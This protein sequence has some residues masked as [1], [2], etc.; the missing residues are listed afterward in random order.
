M[1]KLTADQ[2]HYRKRKKLARRDFIFVPRPN[3][4]KRSVQV[5]RRAICIRVSSDVFE[6]LDRLCQH[7]GKTKQDMVT[8][9]IN[10]SIKQYQGL[11]GGRARLKR[12]DWPER[13]INGTPERR[14][15]ARN[16][17]KQLNLRITSTA[18]KKLQCAC[19]DLNF[20]KRRLVQQLIIA[21]AKDTLK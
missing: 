9:M 6:L 16:T 7:Y 3:S 5:T 18:Y 13:L 8:H 15:Y 2:R 12:Y 10:H 14:R 19:V 4:D 11:H 20:S 21:Y 17:E 1:R